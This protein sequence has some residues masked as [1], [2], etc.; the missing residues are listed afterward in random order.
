[1]LEVTS[2][3]EGCWADKLADNK[4][5]VSW[6]WEG[7]LVRGGVTLLTSQWKSGKTTLLSILLG[8]LAKGG[9]LADLAVQPGQAVVISEESPALWTPRHRLLQFPNAYLMCRPFAGKPSMQQW[10]SL[11]DYV[12]RL[13]DEHGIALAVVDTLATFLPGR[14]E[15]S[16]AI[17]MEALLPL[18]TW[19]GRGMAVLLNHHPRKGVLLPGQ[20]ARG[21]GALAGFVDIIMEMDWCAHAEDDDRRR[22]ILAFSR[23]DQTPRQRVL[24]L[25]AEGTDYLVHGTFQDD[26]FLHSWDKVKMVLEDAGDRLSRHQILADWPPDFPAPSECN[27]GRWLKRAVA[28][29]LVIEK[30]TGK[31]N[32]P[33]RYALP[34][35]E[36][37][38][39]KDPLYEFRQQYL[40]STRQAKE[41]LEKPLRAG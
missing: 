12:G 21:S 2:Y 38:W 22:K 1:M 32:D 20:A 11:V 16:A 39:R 14:N 31:K 10:L 37:D 26:E 25:N 3:V 27:L 29:G 13:H 35:K 4:E 6:L 17:M 30:G 15:A 40:E 28:L 33:F 23:H 34:G 41:M 5:S 8:R 19:T 18:Q 24:E 7:Y 9:T 36:D